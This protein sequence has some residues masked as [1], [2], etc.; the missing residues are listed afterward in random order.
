M[1]PSSSPPGQLR[2]N[3]LPI[4]DLWALG[5]S[6]LTQ[7]LYIVVFLSRYLDLFWVSPAFSYWNFVL[8]NFY[9]WSSIYILF[10]MLRIYPRTRER[11]KA[12]RLAIYATLGSLIASPIVTIIFKGF[13]LIETLY[14]FSLALESVCILPQLLLLR[15]TTVP[16]VISSFYLVTLGS[17]RF[18]YILNWIV[19]AASSEH[20][21]DPVTVIFGIVQ[22]ALYVDFAWVYWTR[23][24]VK[25]R[26]GGIVDSDDLRKSWLVGGLLGRRRASEDQER[27]GMD[28][29]D[30]DDTFDD[31]ADHRRAGNV[32][33]STTRKPTIPNR[34]GKRGVS[35]RA[36]D[37]LDDFEQTPTRQDNKVPLPPSSSSRTT[38]EDATPQETVGILRQPDEFLDD[39]DEDDDHPFA[40][41]DAAQNPLP[42]SSRGPTAQQHQNTW[43]SGGAWSSP[44]T[45]TPGR[46]R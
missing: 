29:H 2:S 43:N 41:G 21:F 18:F 19:R 26:G 37:T 46:P 5:I 17:Y 33:N 34:W 40:A 14:T 4:T 15:Q 31:V 42:P 1:R 20:F 8:K 10:L 36:D 12:W 16:T 22:T 3:P 6:L 28:E 27:D 45:E 23:Q 30:D 35:V 38:A 24:R 44:T 13:S 7:F 25:L 32:P 39:D 9:I 11:E